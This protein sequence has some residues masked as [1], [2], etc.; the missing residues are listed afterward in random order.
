MREGRTKKSRATST[1]MISG[2]TKKKTKIVS[3]EGGGG[4]EEVVTNSLNWKKTGEGL[5]Q[6]TISPLKEVRCARR[7]SGKK[8]WE[9]LLKKLLPKKGSHRERTYRGK[10]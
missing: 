10:Y 2:L 6:E 8:V 4:E 7:G 3:L 5:F 1:K 9:S